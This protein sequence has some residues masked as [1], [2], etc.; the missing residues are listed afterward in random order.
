MYA[1]ATRTVTPLEIVEATYT[2]QGS[3][4]VN[5]M[6]L[7]DDGIEVTTDFNRPPAPGTYYFRIDLKWTD[8]YTIPIVGSFTV[9]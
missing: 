9:P 7:F 8:G 4:D 5:P 6:P 1:I 3:P 2:G